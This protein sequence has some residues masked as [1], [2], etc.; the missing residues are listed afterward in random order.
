MDS[1]T[2][3]TVMANYGLE[4]PTERIS[5]DPVGHVA[6]IASTRCDCIV[7]VHKRHIFFDVFKTIFEV[8]VRPATPLA[9]YS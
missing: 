8:F 2:K 6:S 3:D 9:V 5:L 7:C 1:H 4:L